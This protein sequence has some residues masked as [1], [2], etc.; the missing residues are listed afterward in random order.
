[1][2]AIEEIT[3]NPLETQLTYH[4]AFRIFEVFRSQCKNMELAY[5]KLEE[6]CVRNNLSMNYSGFVSFKRAY[7]KEIRSQ[8]NKRHR[9]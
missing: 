3:V 9:K 2:G 4:A 8:A 7:Y 6:Y 1:M 5:E